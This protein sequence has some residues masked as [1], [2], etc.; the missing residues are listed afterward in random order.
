MLGEQVSVAKQFLCTATAERDIVRD[1]DVSTSNH[2]ASGRK[3]TK[4]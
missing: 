2:T 1:D 4:F 3:A